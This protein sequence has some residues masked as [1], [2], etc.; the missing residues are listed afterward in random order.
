[1]FRFQKTRHGT[2]SELLGSLEYFLND[3]FKVLRPEFR[4]P[5]KE[6]VL[7]MVTPEMCCAQYSMMAAEQRLKD[8]G[9][10]ERYFFA[11]ENDEVDDDDGV[12]IEDEVFF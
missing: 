3:L 5:S 8:A 4:L 11:P 9:Y 12:T 7:A 10:G 2:R 1:M 6:E